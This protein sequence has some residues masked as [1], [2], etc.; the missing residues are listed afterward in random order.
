ML[1]SREVIKALLDDGSVL[2]A[3]R[4]SHHQSKHPHEPGRVTV[5]HP[6]KDIPKGTLRQIERQAGLTSRR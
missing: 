3:V 1:S 4:G 2:V 6:Q 5:P